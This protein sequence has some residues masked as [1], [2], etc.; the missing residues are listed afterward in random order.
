[1]YVDDKVGF[2]MALKTVVNDVQDTRTSM[3]QECVKSLNS[4][5]VPLSAVQLLFM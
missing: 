5:K 3:T 1:M 2:S 4:N